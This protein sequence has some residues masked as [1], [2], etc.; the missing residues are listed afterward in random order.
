MELGRRCRHTD[1][2][3]QSRP[4]GPWKDPVSGPGGLPVGAMSAGTSGVPEGWPSRDEAG[5]AGEQP[6]LQAVQR[7]GR[8]EYAMRPPCFGSGLSKEGPGSLTLRWPSLAS[9][10]RDRPGWLLGGPR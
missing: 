9:L 10:T 3:P 2:Q 1:K 6:D 5:K 8:G 7:R 4:T